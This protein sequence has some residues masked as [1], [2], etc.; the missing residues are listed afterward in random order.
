VAWNFAN[1]ASH[2]WMLGMF[3]KLAQ[4]KVWGGDPNALIASSFV[5]PAGKARRTDGGYSVSGRW[6]FASGVDTRPCG[7]IGRS[8]VIGFPSPR[9]NDS[10]LVG[11]RR[12]DHADADDGGGLDCRAGGVRRRLL[13]ARRQGPR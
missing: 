8:G 11:F 3:P 2:H 4:D 7:R 9:I 12:I 10:W 13:P 1:L 6:P 5:F